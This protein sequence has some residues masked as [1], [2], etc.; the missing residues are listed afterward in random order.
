MKRK[1]F[2]IILLLLS[3]ST[4][5]ISC[6]KDKDPEPQKNIA[7]LGAQENPAHGAFLSVSE[8][9]VYTQANAFM[10]QDKIDILCF[11]ELANGN[12][13]AIAAPGS[14]ITGI[15]VGES[16][17]QNWTVK[18]QTYFTDPAT[19]ITPVQFDQLKDGDAVIQSYYNESI[20]SGN[21]RKRDMKVNDI[22]AFKTASGTYGLFKVTAVEQGATGY[23]E[24]EYKLK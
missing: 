22:Y 2:G 16:A 24:F 19:E 3:L 11:F 9:K 13:I 10:N 8:K 18:N 21:R 12:N 23:V 14:N 5:F 15:F 6:T 7:R 1:I 20:T 4:A 17:P